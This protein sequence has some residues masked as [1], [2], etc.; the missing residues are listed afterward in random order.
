M[1]NTILV[2]VAVFAIAM[3]AMAVGV[4]LGRRQLKGSCGGLSSMT[5]EQ[6]NSL[7]E[8]CSAPPSSCPLTE[9]QRRAAAARA[10]AEETTAT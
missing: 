8:S 7:C 5:D 4:L 2:A 10:E 6:G 9:E 3:G 1:L